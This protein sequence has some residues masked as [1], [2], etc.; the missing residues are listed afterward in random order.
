MSDSGGVVNI[1]ISVDQAEIDNAIS[2]I[3][4]SMEGRGTSG[5]GR[6]RKE[7]SWVDQ[8]QLNMLNNMN[9]LSDDLDDKIESSVFKIK[10]LETAVHRVARMIPGVRE[11]DRVYKNAGRMS[12]GYFAMAAINLYL[13]ANR[14]IR[15]INDHYEKK[16]REEQVL[17]AKLREARNIQSHGE[18]GEW[19]SQQKMAMT[20]SRTRNISG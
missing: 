4:A 20:A 19:K 11:V 5:S 13:I 10:G 9:E 2:Q 8:D 16:K 1:Q 15:M 14:V 17:E 7:K 18:Y 12:A 3:D 6:V